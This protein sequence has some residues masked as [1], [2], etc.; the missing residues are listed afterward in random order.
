MIWPQA[1]EIMQFFFF[2]I[3]IY[4]FFIGTNYDVSLIDTIQWVLYLIVPFDV[5]IRHKIFT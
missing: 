2:L 3:N 4:I 5:M 1:Q